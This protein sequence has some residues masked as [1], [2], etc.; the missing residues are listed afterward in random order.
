MFQI[1]ID[2]LP[3]FIL[4]ST[5]L[6]IVICIFAKRNRFLIGVLP[7]V[8]FVFAGYGYV[9]D[10]MVLPYPGLF[11]KD[12]MLSS[13]LA[14]FFVFGSMFIGSILGTILWAVVRKIK[15]NKK[16]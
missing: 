2:I 13:A 6:Q 8:F 15:R 5:I 3:L 4:I 16:D 9:A 1:D 7:L 10:R 12:F 14:G 11:E